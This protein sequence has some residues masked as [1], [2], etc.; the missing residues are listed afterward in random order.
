MTTTYYF[1]DIF[2]CYDNLKFTLHNSRPNPQTYRKHMALLNCCKLLVLFIL[3]NPFP[4]FVSSPTSFPKTF[5]PLFA[6]RSNTKTAAKVGPPWCEAVHPR[7]AGGVRGPPP[8]PGA[9][10]AGPAEAAGPALR[11]GAERKPSLWTAADCGEGAGVPAA[12]RA[13]KG[14]PGQPPPQTLPGHYPGELHA[15]QDQSPGGKTV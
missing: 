13:A 11:L 7:P 1:L 6:S 12:G 2:I 15:R 14:P 9:P 8:Q 4:F 10:W 3:F 5:S